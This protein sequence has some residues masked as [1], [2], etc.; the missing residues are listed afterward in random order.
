M[1]RFIIGIFYL[2]IFC[3]CATIFTGT[4]G[5]INVSSDPSGAELYSNG[6][7]LGKT[8]C[9]IELPRGVDWNNDMILGRQLELRKEGF[10]TH[11]FIPESQ[12]NEFAILNLFQFY[13]WAL[14]AISGAMWVYNPTD[15]RIVLQPDIN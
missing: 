4:K 2:A 3:S 14:D 5:K 1:M 13:F 9:T 10:L 12:F 11:Y 7:L 6:V 8:P 15:Y